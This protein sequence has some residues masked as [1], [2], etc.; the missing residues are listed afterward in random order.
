M[1]CLI[2]TRYHNGLKDKSCEIGVIHVYI[3]QSGSRYYKNN[4]RLDSLLL[5][6]RALGPYTSLSTNEADLSLITREWKE[7]PK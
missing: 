7:T 1:D 3:L 5:S 2:L 6:H 4:L